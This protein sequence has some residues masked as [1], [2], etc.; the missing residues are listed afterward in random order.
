MPESM[1]QQ[2]K[3]ASSLWFFFPFNVQNMLLYFYPQTL[4][5]NFSRH[6]PTPCQQRMGTWFGAIKRFFTISTME[7]CRKP[8]KLAIHQTI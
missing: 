2:E 5:E 6:K 4:F 8:R 3:E 7:I 1:W